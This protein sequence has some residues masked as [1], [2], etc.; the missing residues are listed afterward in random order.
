V[1]I[2]RGGELFQKFPSPGPSL[3]NFSFAFA[4]V[5]VRYGLRPFPIKKF[6]KRMGELEGEGEN[7]YKCFPLPPQ[8]TP[9]PYA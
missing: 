6:G 9:H 8:K 3:Q 4:K 2:C 1:K 5:E 7:I